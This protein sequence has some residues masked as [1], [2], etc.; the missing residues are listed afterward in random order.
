MMFP[1]ASDIGIIVHGGGCWYHLRNFW[2]GSA[3]THI[4][5]KLSDLLEQYL[6]KIQSSFRITTS[7]NELFRAVDKEFNFTEHYPKCH[8]EM[9]ILWM[10][11]NHPGVCLML[12]MRSLVRFIQDLCW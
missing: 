7:L 6:Y 2:I 10:R 4:S 11:I 3:S 5:R 12:T 9:F 1:N 8:G